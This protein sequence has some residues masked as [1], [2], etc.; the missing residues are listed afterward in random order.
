MTVDVVVVDERGQ[1]VPDLTVN[2]FE[3]L[4]EG[5]VQK[6]EFMQAVG[7]RG[8]AAVPRGVASA[9]TRVPYSTNAGTAATSTRTFVIVFDDLHLT[10]EQGARAR[11]ALTRFVKT[12]LADG[13]LV[14]LIVPGSALRW[15]A[16]LPDGRRMK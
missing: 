3:V 4:D 8:S 16:R 15:H 14:T 2:D 11:Q 10:R 9:D 6:V 1:P 5:A 7:T 12:D 13:D